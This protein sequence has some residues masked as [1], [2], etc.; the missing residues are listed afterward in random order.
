MKNSANS[1]TAKVDFVPSNNHWTMAPGLFKERVT[2]AQLRHVLLNVADPIVKGRLLQWK[3]KHVGVG[4][5]DLWA[6]ERK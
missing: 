3:S 1:Q 6:G 5:H 2:T 4:V